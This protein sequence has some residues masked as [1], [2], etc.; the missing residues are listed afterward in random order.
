MFQLSLLLVK[1]VY[2][3]Y[4]D[5]EKAFGKVKNDKLHQLLVSKNIDSDDVR[6][7]S[8]L[9][10]SQKANE[11]VENPSTEEM[12][13]RRGVRRGCTLSLLLLIPL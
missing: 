7:I 2:A 5:F 6:I 1:E 10:W 4:I 13:V 8:N 3:G 12:K 11:M 9:Y